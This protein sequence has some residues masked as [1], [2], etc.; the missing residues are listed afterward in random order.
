MIEV[1]VNID[2][3]ELHAL[4]RE[5]EEWRAKE[6]SRGW[7]LLR[8][9]WSALIP[10][11]PMVIVLFMWGSGVNED[12]STYRVEIAHLKRADE[13]HETQLAEQKRDIINR[14]DKLSDTVDSIS[15]QVSRIA[16]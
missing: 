10:L 13:R 7:T 2:E 3:N 6:E 4:K 14:L 16:K 11:M 5:F 8:G 9:V 12:R 15:R 1:P